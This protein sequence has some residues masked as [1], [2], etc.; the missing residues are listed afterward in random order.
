MTINKNGSEIEISGFSDFDLSKTFECGQCFRWN[1]DDTGAYTGIAYGH[2]TKLK[3]IN[4]KIYIT[5]VNE[6][7]ET[8]WRSYFDLGRDYASIRRQ[9]GIDGFM[10]CATTFGAGIR[11][12][13]QDKWEALC[14]FIISQNNNITRIKSIV[15]KL[16]RDFGDTINFE[17]KTLYTFPSAERLVAAGVDELASLRCGY[18]AEYIIGAAKMV[19]DRKVDLDVLA[20]CPPETIRTALKTIRGVGDKV[21]DCVMLF[22]FHKLDV[23][24]LDVWMKRAVAL[25]YGPGFDPKVFSPYAGIAQ[26]Y[27]FHYIRNLNP[28][29]HALSSKD[30]LLT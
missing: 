15:D 18:R 13:R 7:F 14:S 23:F 28:L 2:A 4:G 26:Q 12:L 5:C 29:N 19:A 27:I 9:L 11:I 6:E 30:F 22:G 21:A 25:N 1:K 20:D 8:V 17:G 3:Q 24:P 16:C 10:E